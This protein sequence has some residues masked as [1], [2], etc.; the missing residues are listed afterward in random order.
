MVKDSTSVSIVTE[1]INNRMFVKHFDATS[2][3]YHA[4]PSACF[5]RTELSPHQRAVFR[6]ATICVLSLS[7]S[8]PFFR[9]SLC[10]CSHTEIEVRPLGQFSRT[11]FVQYARLREALYGLGVLGL[12]GFGRCGYGLRWT[13]EYLNVLEIQIGSPQKAA[14]FHNEVTP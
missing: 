5:R 13:S 9:V 8:K 11:P 4:A 12:V 2:T 10:G 3:P 7:L 14:R 6:E 1:G